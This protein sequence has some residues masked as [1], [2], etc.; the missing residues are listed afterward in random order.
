MGQSGA[1][2]NG[3]E[4]EII[5]YSEA[6]GR[7]VVHISGGDDE[8]VELALRPQNL[9][10]LVNGVEIVNLESKPGLNGAVGEIMGCKVPEVSDDPNE[11]PFRYVIRLVT[12]RQVVAL[13][14]QNVLLPIGTWGVRLCGLSKA[15]LNDQRGKIIEVDKE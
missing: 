11:N 6:K 13:L 12:S 7:Y 10:Q 1:E 2:H 8:I 15:E 4:G 5:G 3:K 9:T 14:P